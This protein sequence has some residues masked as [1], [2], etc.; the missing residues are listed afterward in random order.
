M[1]AVQLAHLA[2]RMMLEWC[3]VL[4]APAPGTSVSLLRA[5]APGTSVSL[6]CRMVIRAPRTSVSL[7]LER[8]QAVSL[9]L[10]REQ[11]HEEALALG[12]ALALGPALAL[13][14]AQCAQHGV[15]VQ[16]ALG[17]ER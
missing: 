9:R 15:H 11:E 10:E 7:G 3:M 8:E 12:V 5:P 17:L 13:A 16:A 14:G 4:R 1:L 6:E 2:H